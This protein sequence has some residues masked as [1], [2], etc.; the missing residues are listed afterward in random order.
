M[1][2][3]EKAAGAGDWFHIRVKRDAELET[4]GKR[5]LFPRK[6]QHSRRLLEQVCWD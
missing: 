5:S 4:L 6:V 2:K 3:K 1:R